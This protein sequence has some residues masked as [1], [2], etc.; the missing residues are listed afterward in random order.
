MIASG[1]LVAALNAGPGV[2]AKM[3]LLDGVKATGNQVIHQQVHDNY[4]VT[5]ENSVVEVSGRIITARDNKIEVIE[6]FVGAI[7]RVLAARRAQP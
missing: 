1:K 4:G 6:E 2:L 7:L 5:L 3:K